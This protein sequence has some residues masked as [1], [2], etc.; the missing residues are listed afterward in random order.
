[1]FK[2]ANKNIRQICSQLSL[3]HVHYEPIYPASFDQIPGH[4]SKVSG[5]AQQPVFSMLF[6]VLISNC[7]DLN[8]SHIQKK[9]IQFRLHGDFLLF[10]R[11]SAQCSS[12]EIQKLPIHLLFP[13]YT[14]Y[15]M[16]QRK[17]RD[18][19]GKFHGWTDSM[20]SADFS[21]AGDQVKITRSSVSYY[22]DVLWRVWFK[23]DQTQVQHILMPI[24]GKHHLKD[25]EVYI[26][27]ESERPKPQDTHWTQTQVVSIILLD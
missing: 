17:Y 16:A 26:H 18:W 9:E 12:H 5:G 19:R 24:L 8:T 10:C 23:L 11:Y 27:E 15:Q 4:A 7:M 13:F 20:R 6:Q 2:R 14:L 3:Q 21:A 1:M 22:P 25:R